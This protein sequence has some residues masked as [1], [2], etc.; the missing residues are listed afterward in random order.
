MKINNVAQESENKVFSRDERI[1]LKSFY[2][3][4]EDKITDIINH[5]ELQKICREDK[6]KDFKDFFNSESQTILRRQKKG[7]EA[8]KI[9]QNFNEE[10]RL[11]STL[12]NE[13]SDR[14][15]I[16]QKNNRIY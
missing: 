8:L 14:G 2:Q 16:I 5:L 7:K 15:I 1:C 4:Q 6:L 13:L 12:I 3:E 11:I 10:I 9:W